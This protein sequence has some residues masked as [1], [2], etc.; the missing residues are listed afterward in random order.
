[1]VKEEQKI[2]LVSHQTINMPAI[3]VSTDPD[4]I[5][6]P[7]IVEVIYSIS[8]YPLFTHSDNIKYIFYPHMGWNFGSTFSKTY[9]QSVSGYGFT[10]Y[11]IIDDDT[12]VVTFA[13]GFDI[14]YNDFS[15]R[16][17]NQLTLPVNNSFGI[18]EEFDMNSNHSSAR[19]YPNPARDY[20]IIYTDDSFIKEFYYQIFGSNGSLIFSGKTIAGLHNKIDFLKSGVYFVE[21]TKSNGQKNRMLKLIKLLF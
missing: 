7:G 3:N 11:H 18:E 1:M 13:A 14:Y 20:F 21:I 19:L 16:I 5:H 17:Y 10:D 8:E 6:D 15:K 9:P 12:Y 2:F 4:T